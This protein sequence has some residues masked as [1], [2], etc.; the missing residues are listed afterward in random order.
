MKYHRFVSVDI[1]D[2]LTLSEEEQGTLEL[3][4][5]YFSISS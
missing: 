3:V 5:E 2:N 1:V 4:N